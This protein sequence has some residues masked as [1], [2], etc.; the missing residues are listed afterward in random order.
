MQTA[1]GSFSGADDFIIIKSEMAPVRDKLGRLLFTNTKSSTF[2]ILIHC[3]LKSKLLYISMKKI[4]DFNFDVF[5]NLL[6]VHNWTFS[7]SDNRFI[8]ELF[9]SSSVAIYFFQN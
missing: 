4:L 9:D 8:K 2:E 1:V 5:M 6:S 3:M 7:L